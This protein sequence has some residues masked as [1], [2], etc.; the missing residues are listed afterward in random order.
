MSKSFSVQKLPNFEVRNFNYNSYE[1]ADKID[2]L[3]YFT[4][5]VS[6]PS[7]FVKIS[8][9]LHQMTAHYNAEQS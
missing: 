2:I 4:Q 9:N 1:E 8:W 6:A 7:T 3:R 5:N